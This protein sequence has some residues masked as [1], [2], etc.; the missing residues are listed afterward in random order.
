M[1]FTSAGDIN[2][3]ISYIVNLIWRPWRRNVRQKTT[4]RYI[5]ENISST[6]DSPVLEQIGLNFEYTT[7]AA[8]YQR[9][10]RATS[11]AFDYFCCNWWVFH[12]TSVCEKYSG[13]G[14]HNA[15]MKRWHVICYQKINSLLHDESI[16]V[17]ECA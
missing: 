15:S 11:Q 13:T 4:F 5:F 7:S 10:N 9:A 1:A 2:H 16:P 14:E 8:V 3:S 17:T 6:C 12:C